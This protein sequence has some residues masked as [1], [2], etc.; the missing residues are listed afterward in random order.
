MQAL[1]ETLN[2]GGNVTN[3][4]AIIERLWGRTFSGNIRIIN[5]LLLVVIKIVVGYTD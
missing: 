2:D 4:T 3:G 5:F 1:N